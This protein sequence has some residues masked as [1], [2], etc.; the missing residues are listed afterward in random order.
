MA[1]ILKA[2][3]SKLG[4][5][6]DLLLEQTFTETVKLSSSLSPLEV[7]AHICISSELL[8]ALCLHILQH[9]S[10]CIVTVGLFLAVQLWAPRRHE[11][12]SLGTVRTKRS[13]VDKWMKTEVTTE[14][15]WFFNDLDLDKAGFP[16]NVVHARTDWCVERQR[17]VYLRDTSLTW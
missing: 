3:D 6:Q 7:L 10:L 13:Q 14:N 8:S 9:K 15:R 12:H 5:E 1:S 11:R 2:C 17:A 4:L 16:C